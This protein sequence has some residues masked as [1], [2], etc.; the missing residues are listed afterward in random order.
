MAVVTPSIIQQL[1]EDECTCPTWILPDEGVIWDIREQH[2]RVHYTFRHIA[3]CPF[4]PYS[5]E[6]RELGASSG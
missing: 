5:F 2:P 6:T 4:F 1:W 3:P